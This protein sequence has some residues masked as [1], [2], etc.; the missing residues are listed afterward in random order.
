MHF[1]IKLGL[2]L[3]LIP[4]S[5]EALEMRENVPFVEDRYATE[6][7][8]KLLKA[9]DRA[10]GDHTKAIS[11]WH[12]TSTGFT[13]LWESECSFHA[14]FV[15]GN[16]ATAH[17]VCTFSAETYTRL[18]YIHKTDQPADH[19]DIDVYTDENDKSSDGQGERYIWCPKK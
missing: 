14:V 9:F 1:S 13:D 3:A 5:L 10:G 6:A 15:R 18:Y 8:C 17:A 2:V 12:L 11:P 7:N 4:V 19:P 16:E